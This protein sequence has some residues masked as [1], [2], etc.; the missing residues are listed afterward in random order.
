MK[1]F[2]INFKKYENSLGKCP[3]AH[4]LHAR[5]ELFGIYSVDSSK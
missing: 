5:N 2:G 1:E 4:E 3:Y